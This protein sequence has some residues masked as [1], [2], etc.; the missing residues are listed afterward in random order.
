MKSI[1]APNL[2]EVSEREAWLADL[3]SEGLAGKELRNLLAERIADPDVVEQAAREVEI[4]QRVRRLV[5]RLQEL[6]MEISS[7]F[8]AKLM[9][10]VSENVALLNLLEVYLTGFGRSLIELV[11]ALFSLF[12]ERPQSS[13]V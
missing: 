8:E 2:A 5:I 10:R 7:D 3:T 6:E 9:A 4:A 13:T 1:D 12:P 11:N